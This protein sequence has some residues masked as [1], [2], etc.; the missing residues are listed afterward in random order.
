MNIFF[1]IAS[2]IFNTLN[3]NHTLKYTKIHKNNRKTHLKFI[4]ILPSLSI[5]TPQLNPTLEQLLQPHMI[6]T[7]HTINNL[8][9]P[10]GL[11]NQYK[12][13]YSPHIESSSQLLDLIDVDVYYRDRVL[14]AEDFDV[15]CYEFAG[16]AGSESRAGYLWK[17]RMPTPLY[18]DR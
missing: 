4:I 13:R 5:A 8:D 1:P 2:M 15:R 11:F 12:S 7:K 18:L 14:P 6:G 9:I 3:P 10:R 17:L 16:G